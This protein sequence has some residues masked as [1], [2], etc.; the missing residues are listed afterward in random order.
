VAT[1]SVYARATLHLAGGI[2]PGWEGWIDPS[3]DPVWFDW[4]FGSGALVVIPQDPEPQQE[5]VPFVPEEE[6]DGEDAPA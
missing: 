1:N 3:N 4:A 5:A 2:H 6:N